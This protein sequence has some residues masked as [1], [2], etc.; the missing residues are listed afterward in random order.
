MDWTGLDLT[1]TMTGFVL[2]MTG[3][4]LNMTGCVLNMTG[5]VL[6][7]TGFEGGLRGVE[8]G[9][10]LEELNFL[11]VHLCRGYIA[12]PTTMQDSTL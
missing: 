10:N 5:F 8:W 1:G 9:D 7:M 3:F 2:N 6:N 12:Q 4:V 11:N